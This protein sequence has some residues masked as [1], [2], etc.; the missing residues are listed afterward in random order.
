M[1]VTITERAIGTVKK[2]TFD[3][4]SSTGGDATG[5]TT[6][7]YDGEVL[8]CVTVPSTSAAPTAAYSVTVS[9]SSAAGGIDVLTGSGSTGRSATATEYTRTSLGYVSQSTLSLTIAA[10]GDTKAG[11]CHL[12][13]R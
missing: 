12:W 3:W 9:D 1:A 2:V 5:T 4:I 10:A 7:P 11:K 8:L 6:K 13:V